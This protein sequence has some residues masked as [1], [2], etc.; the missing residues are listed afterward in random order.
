MYNSSILRKFIEC[1]ELVKDDETTE[2]LIN[3]F[4][5]YLCGNPNF[6]YNS[7]YFTDSVPH[8]LKVIK[9]ITLIH[10]FCRA[11]K[12]KFKDEEAFYMR[13][14]RIFPGVTFPRIEF[15]F[16]GIFAYRSGN[17]IGNGFQFTI[18][19][20]DSEVRI[21]KMKDDKLILKCRAFWVGYVIER[22]YEITL[23][24]KEVMKTIKKFLKV[25]IK[26]K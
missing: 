26:K 6:K 8:F 23:D 1:K 5:L 13:I 22:S 16:N 15:Y 4:A 9:N 19:D 25:L 18:L 10:D 7:T 21:D 14:K 3:L 20:E 2:L 11:L 12:D 17:S 24:E